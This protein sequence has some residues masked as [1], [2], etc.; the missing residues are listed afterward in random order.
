MVKVFFDLDGTL[1]NLY[2]KE[3]WL[4]LLEKE[5]PSTFDWIGMDNSGFMPDINYDSF[6]S[7]CRDLI[8]DFNVEFNVITWLPMY[9]TEEFEKECAK[10]KEEWIKT[11]LPF[12]KNV[13]CQSYGTPKQLGIKSKSKEMILIDDNLEVCKVWKTKVNRK[14]I[15]VTENF[16]AYNALIE[17]Y[18]EL[19]DRANEY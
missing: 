2:G 12:V 5:D 10:I 7:I 6:L 3:N 11:F 16:N 9:A 15:N 18:K 8:F 14:Y 1:F 13:C 17:L 19:N 4:E